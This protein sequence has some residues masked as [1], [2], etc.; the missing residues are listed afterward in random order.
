MIA[1]LFAL[2]MQATTPDIVVSGKR[3]TDA[4]EACVEQTCP[5]L[6]DAQVSIAYAEQQFRQGAYLQARKTLAAA[7][8]RNKQNAATDPKPVAALYEAYAT[9]SL[10]DG[11]MDV[12]KRAVAGQ[13]RTLRENLPPNDPAVIAAAFATGDMWLSL[14]NG[15]AAES[16]YRAVERQAMADGNAT[17]AML[18]TLRRVG[19]ANARRDISGA[20]RL[21][22]EAEAR[23][24]A[25]DPALRSVLQVVRL[26]LA[27]QRA[28]NGQ[29]DRLV[30]EIGHATSTRPVLIWGPP[31]EPTALAAAR[32][33]A[34]K[35]DL[36]NP[37]P[38]R[39]GD[40]NPIQWVDIGFWIKPDGKTDDVE[41][42][43]GSRSTGWAGYLVKQVSGRRYTGTPDAE[44]GSGVYRIERFSLRGLYQTPTDSNIRR[45]SGPS[46]LE[47]L[48]LTQPDKTV[49]ASR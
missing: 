26:R 45:R 49:T 19:L 32:E 15:R 28:D 18:A 11:E 5:P 42:L 34:A 46:E 8:A 1:L 20:T 47:V 29:V 13:V 31:Y 7:V 10:H 27:A 48:D 25:A 24:A 12:F 35:F 3:L 9:V 40:L 21:L 22:A 38:T 44:G 41:I 6:R 33:D 37:V 17:L 43:R 2:T 14:G 36:I 23:P 16:S 30:R 39:S 4:Y